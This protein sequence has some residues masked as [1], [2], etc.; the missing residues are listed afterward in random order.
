M[1]KA[2]FGGFKVVGC[3][4]VGNA[5]ESERGEGGVKWLGIENDL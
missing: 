3:K 5:A 4:G 1:D 2:A